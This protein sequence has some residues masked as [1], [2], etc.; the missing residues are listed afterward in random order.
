MALYNTDLKGKS[1]LGLA[2]KGKIVPQGRYVRLRNIAAN[3]TFVLPA[4]VGITGEVV[5][6][7]KSSNTQAAITIGTAAAGTQVGTTGT[8]ATKLA[9]NQL[10]T[11]LQPA[12]TARTLFIESTAWQAGVSVFIECRELPVVDDVTAIS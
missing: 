2:A 7:N 3:A 10:L 11:R 12:A 8:V 9:A 4:N 1:R 6:V 5:V